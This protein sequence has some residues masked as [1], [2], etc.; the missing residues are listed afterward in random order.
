MPARP[1]AVALPVFSSSPSIAIDPSCAARSPAIV[2]SSVVLPAP[3]GPRIA[4]T[5]PRST[6]EI[7]VTER[8]ERSPTAGE[9]AAFE[10]RAHVAIDVS[11][12][13]PRYASASPRSARIVAGSPCRI[14]E[15]KSST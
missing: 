7:E 5:V 6:R 15:P 4:C 8:G 12:N 2:S 14:T 13:V 10:S 11:C 3:L 1:A 9:T